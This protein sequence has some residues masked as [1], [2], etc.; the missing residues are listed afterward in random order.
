MNIRIRK[1]EEG[2]YTGL[3]E[4]FR[5]FAAFQNISEKMINLVEKMKAEKDYIVSV[6]KVPFA[7]LRLS[8]NYSFTISKFRVFV[9]SEPC[10][11]NFLN[12]YMT[13]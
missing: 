8:G 6:H 13:V 5:E 3:T 4:L 12:R 1:I 2:D 10:K 11:W 9:P 7:A